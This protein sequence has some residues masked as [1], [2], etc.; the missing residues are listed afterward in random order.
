MSAIEAWHIFIVCHL[1]WFMP[2]WKWGQTKISYVNNTLMLSCSLLCQQSRRKKMITTRR[3]NKK[4]FD[5]HLWGGAALDTIEGENVVYVYTSSF[6]QT[7][8]SLPPL[9]PLMSMLRDKRIE[10][11]SPHV[12]MLV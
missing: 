4:H 9:Q 8:M 12:Y 2:F 3:N 7:K 11:I 10:I 5:W 6:Y 1:D